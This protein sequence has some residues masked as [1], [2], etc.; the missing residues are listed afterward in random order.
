MYTIVSNGSLALLLLLSITTAVL[1]ASILGFGEIS[2]IVASSLV[3]PSISFPLS[4]VSLTLLV[5]PG[6]LAVAMAEFEINGVCAA[7]VLIK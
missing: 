1:V 5:C 2:T 3:L 7:A 4:E 6:L